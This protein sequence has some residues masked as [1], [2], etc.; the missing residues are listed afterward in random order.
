MTILSSQSDSE[1][2]AR[3]LARN[4]L[5]TVAAVKRRLQ[6]RDRRRVLCAIIRAA[7][8]ALLD[9]GETDSE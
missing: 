3:T 6:G 7:A 8:E 5:D 9:D 1:E 2:A 4:G